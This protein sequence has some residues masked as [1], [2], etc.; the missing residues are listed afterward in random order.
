MTLNPPPH[1]SDQ[2]MPARAYTVPSATHPK[3]SV[4]E[5][6][7]RWRASPNLDHGFIPWDIVA[8]LSIT[9]PEEF[10]EWEYHRVAIQPCVKGE[11][12]CNNENMQI[13]ENLGSYFD[14]RN[15]SGVVRTPHLVRNETKLL[16]MMFS[17][18]GEIPAASPQPPLFW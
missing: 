14:G 4:H 7:S 12:S 13:V 2:S 3:T 18:M 9:H 15:W 10:D 8:L 6:S 17:L 11:P 16:E 5:E 1:Q